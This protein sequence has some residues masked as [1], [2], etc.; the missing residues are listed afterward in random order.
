M[1]VVDTDMA[2]LHYSTTQ[3]RKYDTKAI[4][5]GKWLQILR[6]GSSSDTS[7]QI[8]F[9]DTENRYHDTKLITLQKILQQEN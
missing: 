6:D 9:D 8:T 5:K 3:P 7:G 1:A 4:A 2:W